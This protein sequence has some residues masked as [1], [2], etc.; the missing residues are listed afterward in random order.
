MSEE[1]KQE[2]NTGNEKQQQPKQPPAPQKA[3]APTP[4]R[5]F[6]R[7]TQEHIHDLF[8]LL[9]A[10]MQKD[11]SYKWRQ[12][13]LIPMEHSHF[14]HS[15]ND[16]TMQ[17]NK[18]CSAV[19]GHFH[20]VKIAPGKV[21]ANG[22]P[23]VEVGPAL[24]YVNKKLPNGRI[25]KRAE[26]VQFESVDELTGDLK[27]IKDN[28]THQVEYLGSETFNAQSRSNARVA[29]RSK[30][31]GLMSG[32]PATQAASQEKLISQPGSEAVKGLLKDQS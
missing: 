5:R 3:T 2:T 19:G 21:A 18:Y 6:E 4:A 29:E 8:K 20:E 14:F 22:F 7:G 32:P 16:T 23:L 17:P 1:K 31:A 25:L 11:V 12:P 28:H 9:V 10:L 27:I 26:L 15:I 24:T 13:Q 30:V